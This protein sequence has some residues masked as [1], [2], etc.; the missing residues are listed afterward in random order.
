MSPG[1]IKRALSRARY[2]AMGAAIGAGIGGLYS[3]NA[4]SSGA[5][6]GAMIGAAFG[7][8]RLSARERID[9]VRE[10]SSRRMGSIRPTSSSSSSN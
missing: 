4:A 8:T 7:E 10:R 2:A 1:R 5:A 3:R 6:L 9:D